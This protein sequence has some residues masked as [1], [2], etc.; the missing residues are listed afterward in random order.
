MAEHP[1]FLWYCRPSVAEHPVLMWY[2]RPSVAEHPVFLWY[3][4]PVLA[5]CGASC[6]FC[7]TAGLSLD[8]VHYPG[9]SVVEKCLLLRAVH[10]PVTFVAGE[11]RNIQHHL[12]QEDRDAGLCLQTGHRGTSIKMQ[13][14]KRYLCMRQPLGQVCGN[15]ACTLRTPCPAGVR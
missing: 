1:V 11:G 9:H 8:A 10:C 5:C 13:V 3:C 14:V 4:R 7:G 12:W 6:P 15:C 2:C